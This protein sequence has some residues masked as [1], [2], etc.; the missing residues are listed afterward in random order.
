[1]NCSRGRGKRASLFDSLGRD[2]LVGHASI[3]DTTNLPISLKHGI[4]GAA[5]AEGPLLEMRKRALEDDGKIFVSP[6]ARIVGIRAGDTD[7]EAP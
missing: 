7:D 3:I 1:M 2:H 4:L 6:I 5:F